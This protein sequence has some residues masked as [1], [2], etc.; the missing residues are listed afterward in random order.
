MRRRLRHVARQLL[1]AAGTLTLAGMA[2]TAAAPAQAVPA[3]AV[4]AHAKPAGTLRDTPAPPATPGTKSVCGA[5]KPGFSTCM[6]LLR[7]NV[8]HFKGVRS[9]AAAASEPDGYGPSQLQ[10]AY[11]LPSATAGAGE[12]VAVVDAYDDPT[13]E[14]DLQVYRAQ[15]GLP[16]CDTANGCFEKVNQDGLAAPLPQA[17]GTAGPES[18]GWDVEES[19]DIDMVSATCPNCHIL[20]VEANSD[21]DSDLYQAED[22]AV[23]MGAKFVSNSWDGLEYSGETADDVYFNHPGVAITVASGDDGYGTL[24]PAASRDVTA[25]G[26]TTLS[27]GSNGAWTQAAWGGASSGCSFYEPKPA[28]QTDAGCAQRTVA[29][30]SAVADPQTGVAVYDSYSVNGWDEVG[31]TSVAS[32]VIAASY[33]LAGPPAP[34]TYPAS[35][36]YAHS[37]DL[38][39]V[40]GGFTSPYGC[41]PSYLCEGVPGYDGP[42]GLGTP[43]GVGA[44]SGGDPYGT[45]SGTISGKSGPLAGATVTVGGGY[46]ATTGAGGT[47][48]VAV[49][50]GSYTVS[51]QA[52]GY[53]VASAGDVAVTR[54]HATTENLTLTTVSHYY[55]LSG[56]VSDGSGHGWPLYA[57]VGVSGHPAAVFTNPATGRYSVSVPADGKYTLTVAPL[58]P[59]YSTVTTSVSV[60]AANV[61]KN[62]DVAANTDDAACGAPGYADKDTGSTQTFTGWSTKPEDGWTVVDNAGNG[63]VWTFNN[64]A[65]YPPP[66]G[67]T[68]AFASVQTSVLGDTSPDTSLVSP[69]INLSKDASPAITFDTA[70][71]VSEVTGS[72]AHVDLSLD[73]GKRWTTVWA[74]NTFGVGGLISVPIPQAAGHSDVQVR[75]RYIAEYE[76][77]VGEAWEVGN[78]FVGNQACSPTAAGLV[79]GVVTDRNTGKP[80]DGASVASDSH[81]GQSATSALAPDNPN[82]PGG[83]YW[84]VASPGTAKFTAKDWDY[85]S[86]AQSVGVKANAVTSRDWPLSAANLAFSQDA[87]SVSQ[88]SGTAVTKKVTFKNTGTAPVQ[89]QLS[90]QSSEFTSSDDTAS[91]SGAAWTAIADYP[92]PIQWNAVGYDPSNGDVYSAGGFSPPPGIGMMTEGYVYDPLRQQWS[93][94][95]PLPVPVYQASG[96]FLDGKFYVVGSSMYAYDPVSNSWSTEASPPTAVYASATA[97]LNGSLYVIGGCT[98]GTS[99]NTCYGE[100]NGAMYRYDPATNRW[101]TLASYPVP[102]YQQACAGIDQEIV[103]AGGFDS[104]SSPLESTYIYNPASNT[105]SQGADMPYYDADMVYAGSGN[106]LQIAGGQTGTGITSNYATNR[107]T[108]YDPVSNSWSA[109]P[110]ASVAEVGGGGGCG[111]Y[112]VGGF[113]SGGYSQAAEMLPGY[114]Q[115]GGPETIPWL[116]ASSDAFTLDPGQSKTVTLTTKATTAA[117]GQPGSYTAELVVQT[118]APYRFSPIDVTMKV[119]APSTWSEVKGTVTDAGTGKPLAGATVQVCGKYDKS[120]GACGPVQYTTT[121]GTSGGYTLWFDRSYNPLQIIAAMGGYV[122]AS[123]VADLV[124]GAPVTVNFALHTS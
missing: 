67:S 74:Q 3:Q 69:V 43:D 64:P 28:W 10:S 100:D 106:K 44:F 17:A 107:A 32:P 22:T 102:V 80:L 84:L 118:N 37:T 71:Y 89:V 16:V 18:S 25:V 77:Y 23:A 95:A 82:I 96:A 6:S 24:Y 57:V 94:I 92:T 46:T 50:D 53:Q 121:T 111:L 21:A 40:T 119:L 105:W 112:Q 113:T 114:D 104:E 49:P 76:G 34:G 45:V 42:T 93:L 26:G 79:T 66:P 51:V 63:A 12:T 35:Y 73:G 122:P 27:Q 86:S 41:T 103:C 88:A 48:T 75:F 11:D 2:L 81:P 97:E 8:A 59:G 5:V 14:A 78:V 20:L 60:A 1:A 38:T 29:D 52:S 70:Y 98:T 116:S 99:A 13:A 83:L 117:D 15:Y 47:Y 33:A 68:G 101:T 56:T 65:D 4:P 58:Y 9:A 124:S 7:T 123:K 31:G 55:T 72:S 36:P 120:T 62:I 61:T 39:D 108:E 30:V 54:N 115:C 110:N 85:T 91:P 109:L 19:L 90:G 87:L